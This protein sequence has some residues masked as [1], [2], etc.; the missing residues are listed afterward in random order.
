MENGKNIEKNQESMNGRRGSLHA[1]YESSIPVGLSTYVESILAS[2]ND[3][4]LD[5]HGNMAIRE[6]YTIPEVTT[7]TEQPMQKRVAIEL[8]KAS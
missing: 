4:Y 2:G 3:V 8:G 5:M 1:A 6:S 7:A